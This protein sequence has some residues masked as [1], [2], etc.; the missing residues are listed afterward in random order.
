MNWA[1]LIAIV[2][3]VVQV[4]VV[5]NKSISNNS[6]IQSGLVEYHLKAVGRNS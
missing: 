2:P 6:V 5:I 3:V 1:K 4:I